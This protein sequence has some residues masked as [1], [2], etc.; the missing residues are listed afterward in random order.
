M[1][2][3]KINDLIKEFEERSVD[4]ESATR[5]HWDGK[6]ED[7]IYEVDIHIWRHPGMGNSLQTISGNK[8]SVMTATAS[9]LQTLLTKEVMTGSELILMCNTVLKMYHACKTDEK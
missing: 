4:A 8:V 1:S 7:D 6:E 3:E 5:E 9:Y 2:K